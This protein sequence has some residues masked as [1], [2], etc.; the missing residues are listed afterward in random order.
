MPQ[1]VHWLGDIGIDWKINPGYQPALRKEY[2]A[3]SI[4]DIDYV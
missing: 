3:E 1:I 4:L 2:L